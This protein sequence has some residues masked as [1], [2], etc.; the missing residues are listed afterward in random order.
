MPPSKPELTGTTGAVASTHWLASA[1]GMRMLADGGNAFDAAAAA[2]FVLQVVEPHFNGLGGDLS[3]VAH[4]AG[5]DDVQALCAQGPMPRAISSGTFAD[6]GLR[7]IPGS[8]LLP[9]CVPGAF[10]G[11]MRLLAEFGTKRLAE[12]LEPAIGYADKGFPLLPETAR[13]IDVLAPLFR[14]EWHGSEQVYLKGGNAP[15]AGSRFRNP[16]L[17]N[18]YQRLIGG[19]AGG[20]L[21]LGPGQAKSLYLLDQEEADDFGNESHSTRNKFKGTSGSVT[22]ADSTIG[23]QGCAGYA[24]AR[25]FVRVKVATATVNSVVTLWGQPFSIG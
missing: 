4:Q 13:A 15:A 5:H 21:T 10:G 2:G 20:N 12:V 11:W 18:T 7:S 25:A 1:A 16:A 8:G 22:W 6:L 17:A 24:Q 3:L 19:K 9:A 14:A 23:V